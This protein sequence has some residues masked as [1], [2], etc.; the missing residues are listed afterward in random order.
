[1]DTVSYRHACNQGSFTNRHFQ[2]IDKKEGKW[3][4]EQYK[5]DLVKR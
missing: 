2:Y 3:H 4:D 1:V 5:K